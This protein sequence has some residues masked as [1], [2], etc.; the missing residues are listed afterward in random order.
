[1]LRFHN[2]DSPPPHNKH[3]V[4]DRMKRLPGQAPRFTPTSYLTVTNNRRSLCRGTRTSWI[5]FALSCFPNKSFGKE[6]SILGL[7]RNTFYFDK[8]LPNSL[9]AR[10]FWCFLCFF[11]SF[12]YQFIAY[13]IKYCIHIYQCKTYQYLL[14]TSM[15]YNFSITQN[16]TKYASVDFSK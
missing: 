14:L 13:L 3:W 11:W 1:M 8:I 10:F 5:L 15:F 16:R 12:I 9:A 2:K 6:V 7:R 4:T